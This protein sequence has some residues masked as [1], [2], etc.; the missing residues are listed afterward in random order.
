MPRPAMLVAMVTAPLL[1]GVLDDLGLAL[2][3]LGVE[4]V[5]LDAAPLEQAREHAR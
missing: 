3:L 2:V 5:V 1:A 4:D